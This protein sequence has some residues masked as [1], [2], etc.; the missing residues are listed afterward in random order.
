MPTVSDTPKPPSEPGGEPERL[1]YV[2]IPVLA[3]SLA[4]SMLLL[5][6]ALYFWYVLGPDV[7]ARVTMP[8]AATLL[9]FV[10]V[11]VAIML[12]VGYSRLWAGDGEVV[13]R[14]GPFIKHYPVERIAGLRLRKG[15]AWAY[16]LVKDP[17]SET[18]LR[19]RAV[20]AIQSIEGEGAGRKVRELRR[21][22]KANGATSADVR[23]D[24]T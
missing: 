20:L 11:M 24:L 9:V 2:S 7:R 16:L 4:L 3:T 10:I 1:S 19:R 5:A 17:D 12:G 21:W 6:G 14:N 22:L 23:G 8:Q 15:D 13:V 18:G